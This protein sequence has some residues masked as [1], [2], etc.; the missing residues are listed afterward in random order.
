MAQLCSVAGADEGEG[1]LLLGSMQGYMEQASKTVQDALSSM[2]TSDIAVVTRYAHW[3]PFL[4]SLLSCPGAKTLAQ[5]LWPTGAWDLSKP[6]VP[7]GTFAG[8]CD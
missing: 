8:C 4:C 1:S 7:H 3:L 5:R 2:Q 6:L